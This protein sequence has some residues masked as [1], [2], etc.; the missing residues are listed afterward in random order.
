METKIKNITS[1][2]TA[3]I[4]F[5]DDTKEEK[6]KEISAF[7][8]K[9]GLRESIGISFTALQKGGFIV[10]FYVTNDPAFGWRTKSFRE[11][12][13]LTMEDL[14]KRLSIRFPSEEKRLLLL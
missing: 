10:K 12:E 2:D 8:R 14:E 1:Y 9:I 3:Y 5:P 6:V 7:L 11:G 13:K 4:E